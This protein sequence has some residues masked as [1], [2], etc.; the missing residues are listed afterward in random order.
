MKSWQRTAV[1][2]LF[3][4]FAFD[5]LKC[6]ASDVLSTLSPSAREVA[7]DIG[8]APY[9]LQLQELRDKSPTDE[10]RKRD[11]QYLFVK[12]EMTE[13]LLTTF[14]ETR[15]VVAEVDDAMT[16]SDE[17]KNLLESHRDRA[18]RLNN[19][20]NF[21]SG[22]A[23]AMIGSGLQIGTTNPY[24]NA[25]NI[26]EVGAGALSTGISTYALKQSSGEKRTAN[27]NPNLLAPCFSLPTE[28]DKDIPVP[29]LN[30]LNEPIPEGKG[31]SRREILIQ[32]WVEIG[33]IPPPK[34]REGQRRIALL[35]GT[36]AQPHQV[37]I[38]LLNDRVAML[39]DLRAA[40]GQMSRQL[41]EIMRLMRKL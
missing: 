28:K 3:F 31:L 39:D 19:I 35:C 23:L 18:I 6:F 27:V 13:I 30:F 4:G 17:L 8:I 9:I 24:Q 22:G 14:L 1:L 29:I 21:V 7:K 33:R 2:I 34:S 32:H 15:D 10:A 20:T 26:M 16:H 41:L 5:P 11:P 25:G 37:S 38:D 12:Q 36:V 40:I